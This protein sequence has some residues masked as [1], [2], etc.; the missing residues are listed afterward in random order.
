MIRGAFVVRG[1]ILLCET[2]S[3][4][5]RVELRVKRNKAMSEIIVILNV[6]LKSNTV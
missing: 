5:A 2:L 1:I 3:C 6:R 4:F